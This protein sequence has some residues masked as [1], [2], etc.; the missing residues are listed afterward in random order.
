MADS[1][2]DRNLRIINGVSNRFLIKRPE[3]LNR[4]SAASDNKHIAGIKA[5][6]LFDCRNNLRRGIF[7]LNRNRLKNNLGKRITPL[8]NSQDIMNCGSGRRS[9]HTYPFRKLRKRLFVFIREHSLLI[10][11]SFKLF[12]GKIQRTLPVGDHILAV[13]L[14]NAVALK[15][16]DVSPD[17]HFHSVFNLKTDSFGGGTEHYRFYCRVRIFQSEIEMTRSV[18]IG[19]I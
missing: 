6:E 19:E 7:S 8:K 11:L 13:K 16:G 17:N 18:M 14:I 5:V 12:K 1:R 10:K 4:T 15:N 3:I 9:Y 2:N